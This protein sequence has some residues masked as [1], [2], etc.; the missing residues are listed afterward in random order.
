MISIIRGLT[1]IGRKSPDKISGSVK[2]AARDNA[3]PT[4]V[5]MATLSPEDARVTRYEALAMMGQLRHK[6]R[7][8]W[9]KG[10][11]VPFIEK[12]RTNFLAR[13]LLGPTK[14]E[15]INYLEAVDKLEQE[16]TVYFRFFKS[17]LGHAG[18]ANSSYTTVYRQVDKGEPYDM[19]NF[20]DLKRITGWI[21]PFPAG[22]SA[23]TPKGEEILAKYRRDYQGEHTPGNRFYQPLQKE[24]DKLKKIGYRET[25][26]RL[27]AGQPVYFQPM[28][29]DDFMMFQDGRAHPEGR[30]GGE[31][32]ALKP[33]QVKD[34]K[35]LEEFFLSENIYLPEPPR[36]DSNWKGW[37]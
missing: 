18:W 33:T 14:F 19:D 13:K 35:A 3:E 1:G 30:D 6:L 25:E 8:D 12:P 29:F 9:K 11:M 4:P 32:L 36:G 24:G 23:Q 5:P 28:R 31:G 2:Q 10:S 27:Q 17:S 22:R 34:L 7:A 16:E 20:D 37:E 15:Q 26:T 21:A